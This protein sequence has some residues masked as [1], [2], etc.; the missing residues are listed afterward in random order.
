MLHQI[1]NWNQKSQVTGGYIDTDSDKLSFL[2]VFFFC[3]FF[4]CL[5]VFLIFQKK[6]Q[7][8][9]KPLYPLYS[10]CFSSFLNQNMHCGNAS[11]FQCWG[12]YNE[13]HINCMYLDRQAWAKCVDRNETPQTAASHQGL[14]CLPLIYCKTYIWWS[15]YFG[16]IVWQKTRVK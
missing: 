4:F 7:K 2:S 1:E 15:I 16:T 11:E 10:P 3:L 12:S 13:Y 8:N 5:F 6:K 9:K 14:H